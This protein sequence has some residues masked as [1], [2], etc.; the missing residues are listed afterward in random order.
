MTLLGWVFV[1]CGMLVAALA[2]PLIRGAVPPNRW[3]GV[4][5]AKAYA[6]EDH[7]YRLNRYGGTLLLQYGITVALVGATVLGFG[8]DDAVSPA[9]ALILA[10][11]PAILTIPMTLRLFRYARTLP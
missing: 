8:I 7:W 1:A 6:S 9:V 5:I 4:R 11:S 3:Y 10:F 2:V